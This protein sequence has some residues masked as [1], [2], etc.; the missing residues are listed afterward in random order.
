MH[1]TQL[2]SLKVRK[3]KREEKRGGGGGGKSCSITGVSCLK[4]EV[5]AK[6]SFRFYMEAEFRYQNL[7]HCSGLVL[8][9]LGFK[10]P[11]LT[12]QRHDTVAACYVLGGRCGGQ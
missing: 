2:G 5:A 1:F 12:S 9:K 10:M 7:W 3:K 11:V 4:T 8:Q 6:T